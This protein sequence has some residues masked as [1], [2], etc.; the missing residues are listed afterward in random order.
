MISGTGKSPAGSPLC[1]TAASFPSCLRIHHNVRDCREG[2]RR[3][4]R[5]P[6]LVTATSAQVQDAEAVASQSPPQGP[7]SIPGKE[8]RRNRRRRLGQAEQESLELLG[9]PD[10]CK[11]VASFCQTPMGAQRAIQGRLPIGESLEESEL[12]LRQ[13]REAQAAGVDLKGLYDVRRA[14]DA[15]VAGQALPPLALGAIATALTA[16]HRVRLALESRGESTQ[17]LLKIA[18]GFGD[19][20]PELKAS[21]ERCINV[22]VPKISGVPW[23]N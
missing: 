19:A 7:G 1:A 8:K 10:L 21:I 23:S 20:L 17:A 12:L 5:P 18:A 9:W 13:T 4:C 2:R 14:I 6:L 16:A 15:A 11:Q 22:S 3:G